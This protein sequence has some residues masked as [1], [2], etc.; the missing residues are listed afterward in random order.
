MASH[1]GH[2]YKTLSI[3]SLAKTLKRVLQL[4]VVAVEAVFD[5]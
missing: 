1:A 5:C 3:S 4:L 2:L